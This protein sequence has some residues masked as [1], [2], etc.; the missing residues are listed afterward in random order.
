MGLNFRGFELRY[1]HI[2]LGRRIYDLGVDCIGCFCTPCNT[3]SI[4]IE[5]YIRISHVCHKSEQT[6]FRI[7][8]SY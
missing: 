8:L 6:G 1:I 7:A 4:L 2:D 3:V 5:D